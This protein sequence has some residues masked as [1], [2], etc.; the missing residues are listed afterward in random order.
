MEA[1]TSA[2]KK[3]F[4]AIA[5]LTV[6][7]ASGLVPMAAWA[8]FSVDQIERLMR[9]QQA[10]QN[11]HAQQ[12]QTLR[13][14]FDAQA[15]IHQAQDWQLVAGTAAAM[16][17]ALAVTWALARW[18][19][20]R[21]HLA[22]NR[23][24]TAAP[25]PQVKTN[26]SDRENGDQVVAFEAHTLIAGGGGGGSGGRVDTSGAGWV[27]HVLRK[28]KAK[29]KPKSKIKPKQSKPVQTQVEDSEWIAQLDE[30]DSHFW[31]VD[32]LREYE[33]RKT[34]GLDSEDRL[35]PVTPAETQPATKTATNNS[36]EAM[37]QAM[38]EVPLEPSHKDDLAPRLALSSE[39]VPQDALVDVGA[40]VQRVRKALHQRRH[41]RALGQLTSTSHSVLD[42]PEKRDGIDFA[43][44][45][46]TAFEQDETPTAK[47][48]YADMSVA[49]ALRDAR[50]TD[51]RRAR[52]PTNDSSASDGA[53]AAS[54]FSPSVRSLSD[55]ETRLALAQEFLKLG[56]HDGAALLCDEVLATGTAAEQF[57]AQKFLQSLPGR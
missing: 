26:D 52:A 32:A 16:L 50:P 29:L 44:L 30:L 1:V 8:D 33:L 7:L 23:P 46:H 19:G 5:S 12:L 3:R 21:R 13:E 14:Q 6:A 43:Q 31:A 2:G 10:L 41:Q 53:D 28:R 22:A 18:T 51:Q 24:A 42:A 57:K 15:N 11:S 55:A 35:A 9:E 49:A 34:V 25:M 4:A 27:A 36:V 38:Q 48:N 37:W 40:E 47:A 56:Q 39:P 45:E 17:I 20:W 54:L